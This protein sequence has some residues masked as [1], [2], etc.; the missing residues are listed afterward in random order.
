LLS[1]SFVFILHEANEFV[2]FMLYA[3]IT[4][5]A[6]YVVNPISNGLEKSQS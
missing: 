3:S 5:R 4:E 6:I 2:G 1:D